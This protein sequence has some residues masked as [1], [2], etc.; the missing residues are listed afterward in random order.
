MEQRS[1]PTRTEGEDDDG[2][3]DSR[4]DGCSETRP[5]APRQVA[6][7]SGYRGG[8]WIGEEISSA[9]SKQMRDACWSLRGEDGQS[10]S[11]FG[12]VEGQGREAH[13][14]TEHHADEQDGEVPEAERN[15]RERQRKRDVGAH[16]DHCGGGDGDADSSGD[17]LREA[18]RSLPQSWASWGERKCCVH[19]G[20]PF[21]N[22]YERLSELLPVPVAEPRSCVYGSVR[23]PRSLLL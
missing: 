11:A 16:G 23:S 1:E 10:Q 19:Q 5:V 13:D 21:V 6:G 20:D 17:G 18:V 2:C 14:R 22:A 9:G 8:E 4:G 7:K 15:R 3:G 12:E